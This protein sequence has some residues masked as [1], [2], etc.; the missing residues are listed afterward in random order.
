MRTWWMCA[1]VFLVAGCE[2]DEEGNPLGGSFD[3]PSEPPH[4]DREEGY[5]HASGKS[6]PFLCKDS[7]GNYETCPTDGNRPSARQ[8]SCD[9]SGCHGD[10]DFQQGADRHLLGSDGPSCFT[11]HNREW[12]TRVTP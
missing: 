7:Q 12:N 10:N 3:P 8:L 2:F 4:D 11:C 5:A 6:N 1:A 9:A